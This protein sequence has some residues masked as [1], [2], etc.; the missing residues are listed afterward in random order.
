MMYDYELEEK[1]KC[2]QVEPF[3]ETIE[4]YVPKVEVVQK[5]G[6]IFGLGSKTEI[7]FVVKSN[8]EKYPV[9]RQ[10]ED[11]EWLSNSIVRLHPLQAV[12]STLGRFLS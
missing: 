7:W 6:F 12:C 5:E 1:M 4:V 3:A 10:E 8:L 2:L 11:F 9:K